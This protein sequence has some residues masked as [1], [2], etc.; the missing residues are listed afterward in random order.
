MPYLSPGKKNKMRDELYHQK[1]AIRQILT[2]EKPLERVCEQLIYDL[3]EKVF[4]YQKKDLQLQKAVEKNRMDIFINNTTK[5]G[6]ICECKR[7]NALKNELD[8]E[9]THKQLKNYC[10]KKGCEWGILTDAIRWEFYRYDLKKNELHVVSKASFTNITRHKISKNYCEPFFIF[11]ADIK[12]KERRTEAEK[13]DIL[14][15]DKIYWLLHSQAVQ[16]ILFKEIRKRSKVECK[17]LKKELEKQI[18]NFFPINGHKPYN[19]KKNRNKK[20]EDK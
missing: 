12:E 2:S 20:S 11:H 6:I 7:Y 4:C 5:T 9:R 14:S 1:Q 13:Q 8:K 15:K 19:R 17:N 18:D 10:K 16:N 3:L